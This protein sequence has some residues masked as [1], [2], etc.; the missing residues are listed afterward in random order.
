MDLARQLIAS[1]DQ[2]IGIDDLAPDDTG[3][4]TLAFDD[5]SVRLVHLEEAEQLL[6]YS[7]VGYVGPAGREATL[8]ALLAAN[9]FFRGTQGAALGLDPD[10]GLVTLAYALNLAGYDEGR[11]SQLMENFLRIA[12]HWKQHLAGELSGSVPEPAGEPAWPA[13]GQALR[14]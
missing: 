5:M 1:F 13:E 7:P 2:S 4:C 6:I 3:G 8:T 11:F 12:E 9:L 14:V 10:S